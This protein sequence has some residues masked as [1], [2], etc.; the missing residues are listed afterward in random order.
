MAGIP[1]APALGGFLSPIIS[2]VISRVNKFL[3]GPYKCDSNIE[4][5]LEKVGSTQL[6]AVV[7]AA[8]RH[9]Q[10]EGRGPMGAAPEDQGCGLCC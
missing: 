6:H 4:S 10:G 8:E 9:K 7:K 1:E 2:T 3:V 5:C